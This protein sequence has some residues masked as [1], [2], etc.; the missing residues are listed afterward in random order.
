VFGPVEKWYAFV[1]YQLRAFFKR[2]YDDG[3]A[4]WKALVV[5]GSAQLAAIMATMSIVAVCLQ[6]RI[7]TPSNTIDVLVGLAVAA[8]LMMLNY[9]ALLFEARW[10]RFEAEFKQYSVTVRCLS[11]LAIACFIVLIVIVA[12]ASAGAAS[13]IPT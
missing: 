6:H 10:T 1:F 9:R 5:I 7:S 13:R 4:D 8:G 3:L 12:L 11:G 2:I